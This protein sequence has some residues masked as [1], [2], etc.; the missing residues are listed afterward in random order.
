MMV[1]REA[2]ENENEE[3]TPQTRTSFYKKSFR[4]ELRFREREQEG[5]LEPG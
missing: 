2:N 5:L 4:R 1:S 3:D